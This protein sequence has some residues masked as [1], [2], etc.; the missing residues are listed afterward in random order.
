M[1]RFLKPLVACARKLTMLVCA[2]AIAT[3]SQTGAPVWAASEVETEQAPTQSEELAGTSAISLAE[4]RVDFSQRRTRRGL[5]SQ[6]ARLNI[7]EQG[8]QTPAGNSS[9][10]GSESECFSLPLRC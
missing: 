2:V 6:P 7:L 1:K 5:N 10:N 8:R 9:H 4:Q 3:V